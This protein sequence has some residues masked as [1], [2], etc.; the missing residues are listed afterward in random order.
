MTAT[1]WTVCATCARQRLVTRDLLRSRLRSRWY[2]SL[3][4]STSTPASA[5]PLDKIRNIGIIAHIDA[6]KTT[7]TER[8]LY[9]AGYTKRIGD[10]DDGDTVMDFLPA[11]RQRGIT[12]TSAA[13]T[14]PWKGHQINLIDTPGHVDFTIEVE[15]SVRVLDGAVT[16]LDAVAGVEAQTATVWHQAARYNI[17][18]IIYVNKMDR[19]GASFSRTVKEIWSKL[20]ILPLVLQIPLR[21]RDGDGIIGIIDLVTMDKLTWDKTSMVTTHLT[22][23]DESYLIAQQGRTALV[24]A[25]SELDETIVEVYLSL[26]DHMKVP[27]S[28]IVAALRRVTLAGKVAPVFCGASLR[29]LGVQPVLDG[30]INLLPSPIDRPPA[31][32]LI[33]TSNTTVPVELSTTAPLCALAFKVTHDTRRGMMVFV[34]VYAGTLSP[35]MTLYNTSTKS[36]ERV[37]KLLKMYADQVE[38]VQT[39]GAG[40][41]GVIV[42]LKDT[43][44][45]DTLVAHHGIGKDAHSM[46]LQ[47][48]DVPA[49]V[50]FVSIEAISNSA[51]K[52][53]EEA[54]QKMLREDPSLHLRLDTE[55][56]QTLLSGMG[57]LHLEVVRD[58]LATDYGLDSDKIKIGPMR[59]SYR[60]AVISTETVETSHSIERETSDGVVKVAVDVSLGAIEGGNKIDYS[61]VTQEPL[62][63]DNPDAHLATIILNSAIGALSRGPIL[64]YSVTGANLIIHNVSITGLESTETLPPLARPIISQCISRAISK[65][66]EASSVRLMEPFA[67]VEIKD[68]PDHRLGDILSDLSGKRRARVLGMENEESDENTQEAT[69]WVP[70]EAEGSVSGREQ[71]DAGVK[72]TIRAEIPLAQVRDLST[73]LR[74]AT[75]GEISGFGM[76][77]DKWD[78]MDQ[79]NERAVIKEIK[80]D[81]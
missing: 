57:E 28:D 73:A 11:E 35:R 54:L 81:W 17:P 25:L 74:S 18:K 5:K 9:Y 68:V 16:I 64:G 39:I 77:V 47:S 59:I 8:M 67:T 78:L 71:H 32:G 23:Q 42:G 63:T 40:N 36:R 6:G 22:E 31:K 45:G 41:I 51:E 37:N 60:E 75:G 14:F 79:D 69:F 10:V 4:T 30:V 76:V 46:H 43:R 1:M 52:S 53:L 12:I 65:A 33:A 50:F 19:T 58:R 49:A 3:K 2:A 80:G 66:L 55:T 62:S 34:R 70:P 48:I 26:E 56:G 29:H 61:K 21:G 38:E 27:P 7:T 72:R 20:K 13:I 15:R 24:E 44:T